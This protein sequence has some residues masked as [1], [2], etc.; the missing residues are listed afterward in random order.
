MAIGDTLIHSID[1]MDRSVRKPAGTKLVFEVRRGEA[2]QK[3][4]SRWVCGR[5]EATQPSAA[6]ELPEP[7][8]DRAEQSVVVEGPRPSLGISVDDVTDSRAGVFR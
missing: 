5:K 3:S 7:P 4:R 2:T 8:L 1:D 6:A